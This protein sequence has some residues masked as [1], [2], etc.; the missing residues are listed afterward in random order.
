MFG[1]WRVF[2]GAARGIRVTLVLAMFLAVFASA[3][4]TAWAQVSGS[5]YTDPQFGYSLSWDEE[6]WTVVEDG[7]VNLSLQSEST[8]V[9]L[10]SGAFY[11]GDA[12]A[13][14]DDLAARLPNEANVETVDPFAVN[15]EVVSGE[16]D[17]RAFAA[18]AITIVDDETGDAMAAVEMIDCR[19][20]VPGEA[21]LAII[22]ITPI[23]SYE[24]ATSE[25]SVLLTSLQIPTFAGAS[26]EI[27]GVSDG[28]YVDPDYGYRIAWDSGQWLPYRP[29]GYD[30]GLDSGGSFILLDAFD[31][32]DGDAQNCLAETVGQ[33]RETRE[34]AQVEPL[35]LEGFESSGRDDAGWEYSA[36]SLQSGAG[37][38][39][40]VVFRCAT[41][42]EGESVIAATHFGMSS[43]A[44]EELAL[45]NAVF[46]TLS[47]EGDVV[48]A[49]PGETDETPESDPRDVVDDI[50]PPNET[51]ADEDATTPPTDLA[52][53]QTYTDANSNWQI[54]YD[55]A[56]WTI[57][58]PVLYATSNLALSD[59]STTV[60]FTTMPQFEGDAAA[61]LQEVVSAEIIEAEGVSN[62]VPMAVPESVGGVVLAGYTYEMSS[63]TT[64]SVVFGCQILE[65][66]D[67]LVVRAYLPADAPAT[68]ADAVVRLIEGIVTPIP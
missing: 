54:T 25:T 59:G 64:A 65:S 3:V 43:S 9:H 17:G 37:A 35:E 53:P 6:I 63:E 67:A 52:D 10:Q 12:V 33:F 51:P 27:P 49:T 18:F 21:I 57:Q 23:D 7:G 38:R 40:F 62:P 14:R 47:P 41:L 16:E 39:Q 28:S 36:F 50:V 32:F 61:C 24:T 68:D 2:A 8:E 1:K 48:E 44:E 60:T 55:A 22:W 31:G 45:G 66:G 11:G 29:S 26:D 30:L 5:T 34:G 58:D 19:T 42:V 4:P 15:E 13:C 56:L 46:A 20:V